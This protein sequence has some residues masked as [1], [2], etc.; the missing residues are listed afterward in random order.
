ML[1]RTRVTHLSASG[2]GVEARTDG[3][4]YEAPIAVVTV[5]AWA[6]AMLSEVDLPL[7]LTPTL[8]QVERFLATRPALRP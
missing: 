2:F 6:P 5:G 7:P 4:E 1:E 3:S 8:V